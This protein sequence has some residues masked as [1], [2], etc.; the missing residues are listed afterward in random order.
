MSAPL[1]GNSLTKRGAD[2]L[3]SLVLLLLC[4]PTWP[5][6]ALLIKL[7]SR[8]PVFIRQPRAGR[9]EKPFRIFKFRSMREVSEAD[10]RAMASLT[11]K[12][13]SAH[14]TTSF[15][16]LLRRSSMDEVPQLLNVLLGHMSL[17]GPRPLVFDDLDDPYQIASAQG[18]IDPGSVRRWRETRCLVRPGMTGLWQVSGR[19][20]L[21]LEGWLQHDVEYVQRCSAALDL[22][23]LWRT[24]VVVLKGTGAN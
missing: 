9:G 3:L 1:W 13:R 8:G 12:A 18:T 21:P 5:L 10:E 2:L 16:R 20:A 14:R 22:Q 19:S 6:V 7:Q 4:A 23:L 11:R 24:A 15:G 17:V